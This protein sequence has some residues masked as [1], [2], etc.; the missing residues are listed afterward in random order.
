MLVIGVTGGIGTGKT[1]VSR[2][3]RDLGATVIDADRVGH[4]AYRPHS[5]IWREVVATFGEQVLETTGEVDRKRL[6]AIVFGDPDAREKL[7]SIMHPRMAGIIQEQ[8]DQLRTQGKDVVIVEAALLVEAGWDKMVDE[9]WT[10]D[11]PEEEVVDR[12]RHR[13]NLSA[14]EV[15]RR[16]RSQLPFEDRA[17]NAQVVVRNAGSLDQLRQDVE[18]LWGNRMK[19]KVGKA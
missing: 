17:K 7:N 8:I 4:D 14:D 2:I 6:G 12:L 9:I 3:L 19:G 11:S 10:T 1:E 15:G 13:N 18:Y 5:D 16:I